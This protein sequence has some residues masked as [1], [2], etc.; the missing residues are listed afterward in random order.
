MRYSQ[1]YLSHKFICKFQKE[2][3]TSN[4][5]LCVH[6]VL[7]YQIYGALKLTNVFYYF[8]NV[9]LCKVNN[10]FI[11]NNY[12]NQY[13]ILTVRTN[14]CCSFP[15]AVVASDSSCFYFFITQVTFIPDSAPMLSA[16]NLRRTI[17]YWW[18][19]SSAQN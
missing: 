14:R 18:G 5:I 1:E 9:L 8:Y 19:F 10:I 17:F 11:Q 15:F 7:L 6:L 13:D 3:I 2:K 4:A 12:K 16:S